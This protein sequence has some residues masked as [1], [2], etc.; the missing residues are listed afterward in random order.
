MKNNKGFATIELLAVIVVINIIMLPLLSTFVRNIEINDYELTRSSSINI[1]EGTLYGL[2]KLDYTDV[3]NLLEIENTDGTYFLEL[4]RDNCDILAANDRPFCT[5]IFTSIHSNIALDASTFRVFFYDYN[6]TT[7]QLR[8]LTNNDAD[9]LP[10]LVVSEIEN[11][12]ITNGSLE[13][14]I[15][16]TVWIN[17]NQDPLQYTVI[18]G[19]I[20]DD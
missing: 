1:A 20:Y 15:R 19:L 10:D 12:N 4:N 17:Q 11:Q 8:D 3:Y 16:V 7:L 6:M 9:L 14:L 18:S 13:S 5:A 2:N